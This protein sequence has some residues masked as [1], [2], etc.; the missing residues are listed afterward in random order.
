MTWT[1]TTLLCYFTWI[2]NIVLIYTNVEK[3]TEEFVCLNA[4]IS[5]IV[6]SNSEVIFVFDSTLIAEGYTLCSI[7]LFTW[8]KKLLLKKKR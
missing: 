8:K 2:C 7:T 6:S 1:G 4:I 5:G 3:K